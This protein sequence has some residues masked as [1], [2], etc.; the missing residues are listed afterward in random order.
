MDA[1][2]AAQVATQVHRTDL[3]GDLGAR[4]YPENGVVKMAERATMAAGMVERNGAAERR[5]RGPAGGL[6]CP[7]MIAIRPR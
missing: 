6:V 4:K 3:M 7:E 1:G 5:R 2:L